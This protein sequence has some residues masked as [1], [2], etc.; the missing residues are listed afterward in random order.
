[1][2]LT[3]VR[4]GA[5]GIRE[6]N[7]HLSISWFELKSRHGIASDLDRPGLSGGLRPVPEAWFTLGLYH[8]H[9]IT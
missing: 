4:E 6:A 1:M 5:P 7:I 3:R 2:Q 9:T 8:C